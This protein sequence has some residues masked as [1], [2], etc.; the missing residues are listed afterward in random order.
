MG[1]INK[2]YAQQGRDGLMVAMNHS[3][4][5][6]NTQMQEEGYTTHVDVGGGG[7]GFMLLLCKA[8]E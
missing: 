8:I 3:T 5:A 1:Q 4:L 2:T 7:E 6:R